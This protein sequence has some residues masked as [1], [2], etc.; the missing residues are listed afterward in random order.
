MKIYLSEVEVVMN[1]S[2]RNFKASVPELVPQLSLCVTWDTCFALFCSNLLCI[3][4][5]KLQFFTSPCSS[6]A[7][8]HLFI[9]S[10]FCLPFIQVSPL[11]WTI[12]YISLFS[13]QSQC[14]LV[15]TCVFCIIYSTWSIL[16]PYL[17]PS[18]ILKVLSAQ[19][20]CLFCSWIQRKCLY[21]EWLLAFIKYGGGV[22]GYMSE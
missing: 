6:V 11:H 22:S 12:L 14:W 5:M 17:F 19:P 16:F 4:Q 18:S 8:P 15:L 9:L 2:S 10:H 3:Y 7:L 1:W 20:P 21:T 13:Y